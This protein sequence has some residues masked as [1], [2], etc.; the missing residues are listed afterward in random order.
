MSKKIIF[1]ILVVFGVVSLT[2]CAVKEEP[3]NP[4]AIKF[5][6]EY[7]GLNNIKN[8]KDIPYREVMIDNK[9]PFVY[10]DAKGVLEMMDKKESFYVYFGD[11]KCP[12]CRSVIEQFINVALKKNIEKVYYVSI[13]DEDH[14]EILRDTYKLNKKNKPVVSKEGTE[15]YYEL[16]KRF[17]GLLNDYV[18]KTD[19]GKEVKVGEKRIFAPN[20]VKIEKGVAVDLVDGISEKQT[21]S[22]ADLTADIL[23]DEYDIFNKFLK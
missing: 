16:L 3:V 4:D 13:W 12:W 7:E 14:N 8:S 11:T 21:E 15:E 23:N 20:F 18:L 5:K 10:T 6:E 19:K 22:T 1:L 2:S 17:D 9:N